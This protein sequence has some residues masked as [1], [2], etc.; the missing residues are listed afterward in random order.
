MG[1]RRKSDRRWLSLL[2]RDRWVVP[3]LGRY[4]KVLAAALGLGVAASVFAMGLMFTSGYLI[5]ASALVSSII[6]L[7]IPLACVQLFGVGKPLLGY[8]ERLASHDWVLRMTSSLRTRLFGAYRLLCRR[9]A[10]TFGEAAQQAMGFLGE[11]IAHI[12]N[13][14]LRCVFPMIVAWA[15]SLVAVI[16]FGVVSVTF[17]LLMLGEIV[18]TAVVLPLWSAA[19]NGARIERQRALRRRRL[20]LLV[21][22]AAGATDWLLS[23]RRDDFLERQRALSN[24]ERALQRSRRRFDRGRDILLAVLFSLAVAATTIWGASTFAAGGAYE[25]SWMCAFAIGIMPLFDA[26]ALLGPAAEEAG[27]HGDAIRRLNQLG[28]SEGDART[29]RNL[30]AGAIRESGPMA[31]EFADVTFSYGNTQSSPQD[32]SPILSRFSLGIGS[33]QK[34]AILGRSG[35]GK[36]TLAALAAARLLPQEGTV[37]LFGRSTVGLSDAEASGLVALVQQDAYIFNLTLRENLLVGNGKATD[38]MLE[39]ALAAVGLEGLLATMPLGLDTPLLEGGV[40][41]S[42]GERSRVALA[43]AYVSSSPVVLLDEPFAALDE[44]T[45]ASI[46]ATMLDVLSDRTVAVITHDE[47]NLQLFDRVI[48]LEP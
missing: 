8:V 46:T 21:D 31:V 6:V 13:L 35:A 12:Q 7:H 20:E 44:E 15:A 22:D 19:V 27:S 42:G 16:A 18:V 30:P 34:V 43:R 17:S 38:E 14:Y 24:Q 23:G 10:G 9:G 39:E 5:S 37:R 33:G 29:D 47:R 45:Q 40:R 26:I 25:A 48:V 32:S 28:E 41:L 2:R 3:Y 36:S 1:T 4:G 11:D